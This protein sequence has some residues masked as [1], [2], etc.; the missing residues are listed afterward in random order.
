MIYIPIVSPTDYS[1][2][3]T[4]LTFA[5][6]ET[7]QCVNVNIVDDS[8]HEPDEV[9]VFTL[10]STPGMNSGI[11]IRPDMGEIVITDN[12]GKS[13]VASCTFNSKLHL[14]I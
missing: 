2:L 8:V 6:C 12:D 3:H 13:V 9:F 1:S 5:A 14:Y 10:T 11:S 4:T 7:R